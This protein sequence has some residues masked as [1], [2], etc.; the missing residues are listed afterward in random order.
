[1]RQ[2]A[3]CSRL[4]G[5]VQIACFSSRDSTTSAKSRAALDLPVGQSPTNAPLR[6]TALVS[7]ATADRT[8]LARR[9]I[10]GHATYSLYA[11]DA[12]LCIQRRSCHC[13]RPCRLVANSFPSST[14][15][16]LRNYTA[17]E[18]GT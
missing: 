1:M 4:G 16:Y 10:D 11:P 12:D 3:P 2:P 7:T 8:F 13:T 5:T 6:Y 9:P 17:V 14:T 18:Q 15:Q